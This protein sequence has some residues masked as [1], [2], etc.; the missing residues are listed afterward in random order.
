MKYEVVCILVMALVTYLP[1]ALPVAFMKKRFKNQFL[2][3]FLYYVPYAVLAAL[4]FPAI[5]Y[6]CN[7]VLA[8]VVGT[9]VALVLSFI[10][11]RMYW[12]ALIS[13]VSSFAILLLH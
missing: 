8:S 10:G 4:T 11:L 12:V 5:F 13:A 9:A 3:S 1:R 2:N 7:D 6:C